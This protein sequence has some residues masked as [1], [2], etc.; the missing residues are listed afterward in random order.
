M[1]LEVCY[2]EKKKITYFILGTLLLPLTLTNLKFA[3]MF[4][5]VDSLKYLC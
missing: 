4:N 5:Y 3:Y 1:P 2:P